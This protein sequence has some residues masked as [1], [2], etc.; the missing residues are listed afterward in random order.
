V[1]VTRVVLL[2]VVLM[3]LVG[4]EVLATPA[5]IATAVQSSSDTAGHPLIGSWLLY[6]TNPPAGGPPVLAGVATFF[7]DGN[8]VVT[9]G[10]QALQGAWIPAGPWTATVTVVAPS[11][12]GFGELNRLR[13]SVEVATDGGPLRGTYSFDLVG[14]DGGTAFTYRGPLEGRRVG[15]QPPDPL[16]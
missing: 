3:G 8:A 12:G 16:P 1:T 7:A 14:A 5:P 13:A 9:F 4:I 15:V 11:T 6:E 2:V 10:D